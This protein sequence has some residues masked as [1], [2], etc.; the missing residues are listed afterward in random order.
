MADVKIVDI[1]SEQWNIKDQIEISFLTYDLTKNCRYYDFIFKTFIFK[2]L[3][4]KS[5][6]PTYQQAKSSYM[7][8][9]T[10]IFN[11]FLI[12]SFNFTLEIFMN[13]K[14]QWIY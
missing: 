1:D 3:T 9:N 7:Y 2:S 14:A 13:N 12:L 5:N 8:F 10:K 4:R 6:A 11:F